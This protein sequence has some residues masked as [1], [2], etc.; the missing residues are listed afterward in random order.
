MPDHRRTDQLVARFR[1]LPV[2]AREVWQG[3]VVRMPAW[4]DSDDGGEPFRPF[5][6]LWVS[7]STG[8]MGIELEPARDAHGPELL[9]AGLLRFARDEKKVL[10][11]RASRLEVPGAEARDYLVQALGGAGTD[12]AVVPGL[13]AV[14]ATLAKCTEL[15]TEDQPPGY[16][17]GR[18]VTVD[19]VREFAD[20]AARY[21]AAAPWQHLSDED[22]LEVESPAAPPGHRYALVLGNAGHTFGLAFYASREQHEAMLDAGSPDEAGE[23]MRDA[24]SI[25]FDSA[26]GIPIR[27]HDLW[28][29]HALP[30]A[31]PRA[32]PFAAHYLGRGRAERPARKDLEFAGLVLRAVA[33]TSEQEMDSGRW[34]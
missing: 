6:A 13:D 34:T 11:G 18:G 4:I 17:E 3:A 12:I 14:A 15:A 33:E 5:G 7:L 2:L 28:L 10:G 21:Y 26:D 30:L 25:V 27:D 31:G 22:L 32:Y 8:R 16:L 29:D 23:I 1:Q 20:A 9:V 19:G 24:R